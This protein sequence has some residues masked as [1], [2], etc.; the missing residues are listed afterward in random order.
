MFSPHKIIYVEFFIYSRLTFTLPAQMTKWDS[1]LQAGFYI[2]G[3]ASWP[4][5]EHAKMREEMYIYFN[6]PEPA[7]GIQLSIKTPNI[8]DL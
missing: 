8:R 6:I 2:S 7:F 1:T 5:H 4:R 3:P